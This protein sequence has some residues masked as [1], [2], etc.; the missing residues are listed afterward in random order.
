MHTEEI[1]VIV[2]LVEI[3]IY[4]RENRRPPRAKVYRVKIDGVLYD[5]TQREVT[6]RQLL[7][8]AGKN[9]PERYQLD[10]RNHGGKYVPVGLAEVV[11]LCEP[12][13]EVFETF[14]LDEREG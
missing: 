5:F 7:E 10:K 9:P 14:P 13:I 2:E 6:G 12:G 8:R 1:E 11:D 3:E 4:G